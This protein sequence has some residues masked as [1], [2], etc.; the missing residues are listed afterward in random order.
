MPPWSRGGKLYEYPLHPVKDKKYAGN[1]L[2]NLI[3]AHSPARANQAYR[4]DHMLWEEGFR[5]PSARPR[6]RRARL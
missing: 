2:N 3:G 5:Q 1:P 6:R 4:R